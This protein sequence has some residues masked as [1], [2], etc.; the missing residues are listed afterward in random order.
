MLTQFAS[1]KWKAYSGK[2]RV[3]AVRPRTCPSEWEAQSATKY[4]NTMKSVLSKIVLSDRGRSSMENMG[5]HVLSPSLV[6]TP[7][8][9]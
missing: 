8:V 4:I 3:D 2:K 7:H 1:P 5:A 6:S 9:K